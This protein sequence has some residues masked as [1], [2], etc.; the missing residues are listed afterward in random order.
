MID[1]IEDQARPHAERA[2]GDPDH[3]L[4]ARWIGRRCL[5]ATR[6]GGSVLTDL[7]QTSL[8]ESD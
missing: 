7:S 2:A 4:A 6:R 1:V 3:A 8:L 5:V